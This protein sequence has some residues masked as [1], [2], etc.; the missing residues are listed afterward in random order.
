[1]SPHTP[2]IEPVDSTDRTTV[3]T[4]LIYSHGVY[5]SSV[6]TGHNSSLELGW[7]EL[8]HVGDEVVG[9]LAL[10]LLPVGLVLEAAALVVLEHAVTEDVAHVEGVEEGHS[11]VEPGAHTP[12]E[13]HGEIRQVVEVTRQTPVARGEQLALVGGSIG[14]GAR[15]SDVLGRLAPDFALAVGGTELHSEQRERI[16]SSHVVGERERE[17]E[18]ARAKTRSPCTHLLAHWKST[19]ESDVCVCATSEKKEK[20]RRFASHKAT[21]TWQQQQQQ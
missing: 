17:R 18:R 1:M 6:T 21:R 9:H 12:G 11:V 20:K 8:E 2:L 14:G 5:I 19:R 15:G 13:R 10:V 16:R 7:R 4:T 3:V